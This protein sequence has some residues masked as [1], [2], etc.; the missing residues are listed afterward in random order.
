[1]AEV[2]SNGIETKN[3]VAETIDDNVQH[4]KK[5]KDGDRDKQDF[6][7]RK[8][9][10]NGG[11]FKNQ[12]HDSTFA[13]LLEPFP[14]FSDIPTMKREFA[15]IDQF[16]SRSRNA[17][18][19]NNIK[20]ATDMG[21][22]LLRAYDS[23]N[24]EA[25]SFTGNEAIFKELKEEYIAS[26]AAYDALTS[27][28]ESLVT[29]LTNENTTLKEALKAEGIEVPVAESKGNKKKRGKQGNKQTQ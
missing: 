12:L 17:G 1:M 15:D 9:D 29:Q 19:K 16:G 5:R 18:V 24:K 8:G 28:L 4:K 22:E 20:R 23:L 14:Q 3:E 11:G 13:D 25:S 2:E 6:E 27:H 10:R 7:R 21:F 26:T